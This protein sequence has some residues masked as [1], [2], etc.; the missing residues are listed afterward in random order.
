MISIGPPGWSLK[1]DHM[2]LFPSV[3]MADVMSP[4]MMIRTSDIRQGGEL[5]PGAEKVKAVSFP[6][7]ASISV[8]GCFIIYTWDGNV[9]PC[10]EI[11]EGTEGLV[12]FKQM[13]YGYDIGSKGLNAWYEDWKPL[14]M[15]TIISIYGHVVIG[16]LQHQFPKLTCSDSVCHESCLGHD[17]PSLL[18][19]N[20]G[21]VLQCCD[22]C[23]NCQASWRLI[24][25]H[26]SSPAPVCSDFS[27]LGQCQWRTE[28]GPGSGEKIL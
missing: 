9:S 10:L 16:N 25:A 14:H 17:V 7:T 8:P 20:A 15:T 18:A 26:Q 4:M 11:Q 12:V 6:D 2:V 27:R 13:K 22:S 3:M 19:R 1:T 28:A 21:S 5:R 23:Y 24:R